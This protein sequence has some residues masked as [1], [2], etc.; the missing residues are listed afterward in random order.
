MITIGSFFHQ[1][2]GILLA[3]TVIE[4]T[5]GRTDGGQKQESLVKT[6]FLIFLA[7]ILISSSAFAGWEV[8]YL[9]PAGSIE[10][11]A[12]GVSGGEQVGYA[13][14]GSSYHAGL[15]SGTAASWVDLKPAG[16]TSSW[17]YGVSGGQQVGYADIGTREHAGLWSGT[18][19]SWVDLNPA[20]SFWSYAY[21][22]SG[23][24]QVGSTL[25]PLTDYYTHAS[26]WSGTAA[27]WVDLDPAGSDWGSEARGVSDGQQVGFAYF[28]GR[29]HAGLWSGT[30]ASWVD[31]DPTGTG[32]SEAFGISGGQQVGYA[33]LAGH[34]RASL[35]SGTA[36]SW[37]DLNP[38]EDTDSLAYG[39]S[40]G[41]QVGYAYIGGHAHAGLWSGTAASWMD[42]HGFL[43]ANYTYS[44][45]RGIEVSG[46][47]VWVAGYAMNMAVG[48]E[49][50]ILWHN[51]IPEPSSLLALSAG[52]LALGG[53]IRKKHG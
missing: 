40:N 39:V 53:I 12:W 15:W 35:W 18:A 49:E 34:S 13:K 3:E 48:R 21:G 11:N 7:V 6:S 10:S 8:T 26:L 19:A 51:V 27:S 17:A 41:K 2:I 9:H 43:S 44:V 1:P 16:S 36:A 4:W 33:N 28:D 45:A 23:G 14:F 47:D 42:L 52:L 20:G 31:L 50:A 32:W 46:N 5:I 22:I 37:V 38:A 24:Q 29:R 30:A 25:D